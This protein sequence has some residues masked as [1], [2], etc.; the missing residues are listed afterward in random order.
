MRGTPTLYKI[1][2]CPVAYFIPEPDLAFSCYTG[3]ET[4]PDFIFLYS[5]NIC[6]FL[7]LRLHPKTDPLSIPMDT[8]S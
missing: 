6:P 5:C 3:T 8:F 1:N 4:E 7:L 2:D